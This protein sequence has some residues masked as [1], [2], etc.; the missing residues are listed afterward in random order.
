M[1]S[2]ERFKLIPSVYLLLIKSDRILLTRR[3]NTGFEDG[4]YGLPAGHAEE[5]ESFREALR[6][7]A[8][9]EIGI[10]LDVE[11]V[12]LAHTMHRSCGDHE[13]V[14]LFFT[15]KEWE[16]EIE[17]REPDK[18]D[19]IGWFPVD[20]LPL[21]TIEYVRAAIRCSE[22]RIPYSEFGWKNEQN[23]L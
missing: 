20:R 8:Y 19:H 2:R 18:C 4:N 14:D 11:K 3:S 17:N 12:E 15:A 21:N 13:R 1:G 5:K 9:E 6:R 10:R 7:E 16:G 23:T 22:E